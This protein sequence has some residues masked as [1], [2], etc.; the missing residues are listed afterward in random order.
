MIHDHLSIRKHGEVLIDV[1]ERNAAHPD[2]FQIPS[3]EDR[4]R[5]DFG[6]FVKVCVERGGMGERF[7]IFVLARQDDMLCGLVANHLG[8]IR[9]LADCDLVEIHEDNICVIDPD[10]VPHGIREH[11][12]RILFEQV[13]DEGNIRVERQNCNG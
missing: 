13:E 11:L 6:D 3:L 7:W 1:V 9:S 4:Q 8:V 5:V 10:P 12:R 2:T